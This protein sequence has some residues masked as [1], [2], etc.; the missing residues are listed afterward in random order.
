[1]T[2]KKNK[3]KKIAFV[4]SLFSF[5]IW[6]LLGTGASLAW[7]SDSTPVLKNVFH[8]SDFE[9]QLFHR[10][11]NGDW[12]EVESDTEIFNKDALYEPG[13]VQKVYLKVKNN[14]DIPFDW[15]TAISVYDRTLGKNIYDDFFDLQDYLK[16]GIVIADTEDEILALTD[17]R[18]KAIAIADSPLLNNYSTQVA[19]INAGGEA[20]LSLI[21][22]MPEEVTNVAN[23]VPPNQPRLFLGIIVSA[24]QQQ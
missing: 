19:S 8:F 10:L 3:V 23:Y 24:T 16:F 1:M 11:D 2:I 20:Y 13:Y 17:T 22:R 9:L 4:L 12:D 18:D 7:F 21:V 6:S 15:K 5:I 14:G